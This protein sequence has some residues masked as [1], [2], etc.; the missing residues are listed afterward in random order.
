M[1]TVSDRFEP[2]GLWLEP[3]Q[4]LDLRHPLRG[5]SLRFWPRTI[6]ECAAIRKIA[7]DDPLQQNR[8]RLA[9]AEEQ[10]L[11]YVAATRSCWRTV[12]APKKDLAHTDAF[13]HVGFDLEVT[14]EP[15]G[16]QLIAQAPSGPAH[17][18]LMPCDVTDISTNAEELQRLTDERRV[19]ASH[20]A[21]WVDRDR[22]T[23][24]DA[25]MEGALLTGSLKPGLSA[26]FSASGLD[27]SSY[28]ETAR[29]EEI[30]RLGPPIVSRGGSQW[31]RVGD[32][33]HAYLALPS[34]AWD[35]PRQQAVAE[36]LVRQWGVGSFVSA[37][38]LVTAGNRWVQ[39]THAEYPGAEIA[40]EV[41]VTWS[42]PSH[43]RM[44]GWIDQ[45]LTLPD[46][47]VVL[48]DHKT[49]PGS[50]PVDHARHHYV[51]QLL[52]YRSAVDEALASALPP[53]AVRGGSRHVCQMLVH[54]P[55]LGLVLS[56]R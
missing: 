24:L 32:C 48:V 19:E 33:V 2:A 28:A 54:L 22:A 25:G 50:D 35:E 6:L 12:L 11:F 7:A 23:L 3:A 55:L 21:A 1:P 20:P 27:A 37:S 41:P 4:T 9:Q 8:E 13:S 39:W 14:Q 26:T 47:G 44:Q 29:V 49:Y 18:L 5:R 10:R 30:A 43:Q 36:R 42:N 17:E 31:D 52:T 15:G 51:E 38:S 53:G 16:L 56:I 45:L 46:G 34:A 40:T